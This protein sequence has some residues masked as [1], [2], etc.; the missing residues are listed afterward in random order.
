MFCHVHPS[1][2]VF[3]WL[4]YNTSPLGSH[5]CSLRSKAMYV[6]L[7]SKL[8]IGLSSKPCK[9]VVSCCSCISDHVLERVQYTKI[10]Y[11]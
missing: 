7:A 2:E 6:G 10:K 4:E 5:V 3:P 11:G 1:S 8:C 9:A